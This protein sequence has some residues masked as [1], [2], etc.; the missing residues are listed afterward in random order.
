[1]PASRAVAWR[2]TPVIFPA[3]GR[4]AGPGRE[5]PSTVGGADLILD[6]RRIRDGIPGF[7]GDCLGH[8]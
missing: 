1:M 5:R 6:R 4:I 3:R 7:D 8:R 2:Q